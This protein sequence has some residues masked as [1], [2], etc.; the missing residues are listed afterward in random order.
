[1]SLYKIRIENRALLDIQE[2]FAYYEGKV[3]GL[4]IRF[5]QSV[6]HSFE[7]LKRNPFYRVIWQFQVFAS[8]EIS[9]Y[10]PL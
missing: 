1:M 4:G 5:N 7:T 3:Q 9:V 6:F 2:G 10:D 8:K